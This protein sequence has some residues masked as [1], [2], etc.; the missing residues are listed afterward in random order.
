MEPRGPSVWLPCRYTREPGWTGQHIIAHQPNRLKSLTLSLVAHLSFSQLA[1]AWGLP[2]HE[3]DTE[4]QHALEPKV[5][6]KHTGD[7]K[8]AEV[9]HELEPEIQRKHEDD[10][11]AKDADVQHA[12]EPEVQRTREA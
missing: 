2:Q 9:L 11:G 5:Q 12:L 6:R 1:R 8:D 4:V 10:D 7:A 3:G